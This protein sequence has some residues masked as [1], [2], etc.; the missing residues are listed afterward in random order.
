[1]EYHLGA[2]HH[3]RWMAKAIYC[4]KI[5]IFRDQFKMSPRQLKACQD[6]CIFIVSIYVKSWIRAHLAIEAQYQDLMFVKKLLEYE[7]IDQK[8]ALVSLKKMCGHLW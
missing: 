4:I 8:V 6:T 2:S 1:M 5:F 3:A 7:N